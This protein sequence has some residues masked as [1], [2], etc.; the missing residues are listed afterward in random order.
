MSFV[1]RTILAGKAVESCNLPF[2]QHRGIED[3]HRLTTVNYD[4][5]RLGEI[6]ISKAMYIFEDLDLKRVFLTRNFL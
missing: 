3:P 6:L 1:V 5:R 4:L 2:E